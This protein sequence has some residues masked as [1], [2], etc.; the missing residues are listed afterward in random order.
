MTSQNHQSNEK[1]HTKKKPLFNSIWALYPVI[2]TV[3]KK[4][5]YMYMYS[6]LSRGKFES[7]TLLYAQNP[8]QGLECREH[9]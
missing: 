5:K 3:N 1:L 9:Q 4:E 7:Y 8:K 2:V 6:E